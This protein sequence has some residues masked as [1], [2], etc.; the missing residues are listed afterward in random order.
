MKSDR[1]EKWAERQIH[2]HRFRGEH[3]MNNTSNTTK[4]NPQ[5]SSSD[6]SSTACDV[7]DVRPQTRHVHFKTYPDMPAYWRDQIYYR[8]SC[9]GVQHTRDSDGRIFLKIISRYS[10][11]DPKFRRYHRLTNNVDLFSQLR[12]VI[13]YTADYRCVTHGDS[14]YGSVRFMW[15]HLAALTF[16]L[17]EGTC[18]FRMTD[19]T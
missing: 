5:V 9:D 2:R 10:A 11:S 1:Q 4:S 6:Q 14:G 13:S 18:T 3:A 17:A 12:V 7:Q 8:T 15:G 16:S 19:A